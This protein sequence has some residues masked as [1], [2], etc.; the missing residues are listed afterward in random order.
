[1]RDFLVILVFS[2]LFSIKFSPLLPMDVGT[3]PNHVKSCVLWLCGDL[4]FNCLPV[5]DFLRVRCRVFNSAFLCCLIGDRSST[6][7]NCAWILVIY[8][9]SLQCWKKKWPHTVH[10]F[11]VN[12]DIAAFSW[13][14]C[15][16]WSCT[17]PC[18]TIPQHTLFCNLCEGSHQHCTG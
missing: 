5:V 11:E 18:R 13:W 14:K 7:V 4:V 12:T 2:S 8:F 16:D 10:G 15:K 9:Q 6:Q 1:M 3:L 17:Q